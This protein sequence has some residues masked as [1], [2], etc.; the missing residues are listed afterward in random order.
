[1]LTGAWCR[2]RGAPSFQDMSSDALYGEGWRAVTA[3]ILA[4]A[5][6]VATAKGLFDHPV[7]LQVLIRVLGGAGIDCLGRTSTFARQ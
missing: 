7:G 5:E 2:H 6:E 3:L 4:A 1:M